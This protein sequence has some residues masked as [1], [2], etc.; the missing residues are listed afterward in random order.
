MIYEAKRSFFKHMSNIVRNF[1]NV[2][3][4]LANRHQLYMCYQMLD[5][6]KYLCPHD[7]HNGGMVNRALS[8]VLCIFYIVSCKVIRDGVLKANIRYFTT[9]WSRLNLMEVMLYV[10]LITIT[11]L[12]DQWS[13]TCTFTEFQFVLCG[14]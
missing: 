14:H 2:P 7:S 10:I 12:P 6:D 9:T 1:K 13:N 5:A 4:T 3:K 8:L 11:V